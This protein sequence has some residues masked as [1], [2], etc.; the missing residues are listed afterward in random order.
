MHKSHLKKK[1]IIMTGFVVKGRVTF[2]FI[3]LCMCMCMCVCVCVH[4][5]ILHIK[6]NIYLLIVYFIY[7]WWVN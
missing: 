6:V 3:Y 2:V 4:A 5:F 1:L 7:K